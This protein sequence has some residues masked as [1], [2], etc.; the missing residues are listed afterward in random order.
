MNKYNY[1][2]VATEDGYRLNGL[3]KEGDKSKSA[4]VLIHGFTSDFYSH[5]F[6]HSIAEKLESQGNAI[7]LAQNR[8]TGIETEFI[9]TNGDAEY[10]GSFFEKIEEAHFDISAYVE[11]LLNEGYTKI[12][13]AGHSLGTIKSVRYLFEGKHK[14][15]ISKL[16]L[17]APFDKN[18]F[19]EVKAPG[20]WHEFIDLAKKK[21]DDGKGREIVP[22]PEWEDFAISY[23]T[24]Y[25]WYKQDDLNCMWDFYRKDYDFPILQKINIPVKI[26]VG[27]KDDFLI[28]KQLGSVPE[29]ALNVFNKYIK[30]SETVFIKGAVHTYTDH[31]DEVATEVAKFVGK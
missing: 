3:Y 19:M 4:V 6:Y 28:Y 29:D 10:V 5:K 2:Q 1:I 17:L 13:L 21:I 22:V 20:K 31:E 30:D 27:D 8:G 12:V 14:D 15:K 9:K 26:I 11:F 18:A 16:V 23:T 24:F 7:I 25:S